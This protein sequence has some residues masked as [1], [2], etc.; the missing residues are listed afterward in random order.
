MGCGSNGEYDATILS[1]PGRNIDNR[2]CL[3]SR[4]LVGHRVA[5]P[6][7]MEEP[8][9]NPA[10]RRLIGVYSGSTD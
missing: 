10:G 8:P 5:V 3:T 4:P 7:G 9:A 1:S 6:D 2:G